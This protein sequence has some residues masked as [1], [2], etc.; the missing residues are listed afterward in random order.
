M[1]RVSGREI[2]T[3]DWELHLFV[4]HDDHEYSARRYGYRV[5]I[6]HYTTR[7]T[8][9]AIALAWVATAGHDRYSET[10]N[11][12]IILLRILEREYSVLGKIK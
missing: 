9:V 2:E 3:V 11:R 6:I 8:L 1:P 7:N 5:C 4:F 12:C 10:I